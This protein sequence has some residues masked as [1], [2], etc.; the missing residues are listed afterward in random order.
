[1][2]L[3]SLF[4]VAP[5]PADPAGLTILA[6]IAVGLLGIFATAAIGIFWLVR[7]RRTNAT[8]IE[9]PANA[10]KFSARP[11]SRVESGVE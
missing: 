9:P 2:I 3:L 8:L 5:G 4:D 1:M 7:R 6:V 11:E 10:A